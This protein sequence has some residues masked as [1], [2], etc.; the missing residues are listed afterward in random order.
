M[1]HTAVLR[2]IDQSGFDAEPV[3]KRIALVALATDHSS[4]RDYARICDPEE[5]G[6]YVNRIAFENPTTPGSLLETGPRLADAAAEILPDEKMDV[7]AYACTAASV[8][9]GDAR[10]AEHLT[11]AKPGAACVTPTSAAFA[12]FDALGLKRLSILTPYSE[13]VTNELVDYFAQN[14]ID[15]VNAV[16]LGLDDDRRMARVS[17][18][19]ILEA[20]IA[21]MTDRA[22][23]LFISCTA[24]RALPSV[25]GLERALGS[26]VVTSNQAMVWRSLRLAGIS[27]RVEGY[28]RL[29]HV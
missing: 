20:G 16:C 21:A 22:D 17:P 5:V 2:S 29:F 6:V 19:T 7:V 14:G 9:L 8:I 11:S 15:V 3:R 28:G 13:V 1:A 23:G 4:E 10:V 12:A 18:K 25:E 27:R 24:L 26:P